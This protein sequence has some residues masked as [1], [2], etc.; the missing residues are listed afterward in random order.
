M[1]L[2]T[3]IVP[4]HLSAEDFI[5]ARIASLREAVPKGTQL[6]P[7]FANELVEAWVDE[8][9]PCED[10]RRFDGRSSSVSNVPDG[11]NGSWQ[12]DSKVSFNSDGFYSTSAGQSGV[13]SQSILSYPLPPPAPT[14]AS[15]GPI[16]WSPFFGD[17][18]HAPQ[19]LP[20]ALPVCNVATQSSI[21]V[22]HPPPLY[23][24]PAVQPVAMEYEQM[25]AATESS[26]G[27]GFGRNSDITLS[28]LQLGQNDPPSSAGGVAS[29][30]TST[31][32]AYGDGFHM[33]QHSRPLGPLPY[34][35]GL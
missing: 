18:P 23:G 6:D 17:G 2:D 16:G 4:P 21:G 32:L 22:F 8:W 24:V 12:Q 26:L 9:I 33:A 1:L 25:S 11:T 31:A 27:S 14:F 30:A 7:D 19:S 35:Q 34:P 28:L 29:I 10:H 20:L 13:G 5:A 15:P 3:L